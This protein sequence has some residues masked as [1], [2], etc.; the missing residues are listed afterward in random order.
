MICPRW[1]VAM[2]I[3]VVMAA[4]VGAGVWGAILLEGHL[5]A[6]VRPATPRP[7]HRGHP[8]PCQRRRPPGPGRTPQLPNARCRFG[9]HPAPPAARAP[10]GRAGRLWAS[11]PMAARRGPVAGLPPDRGCAAGLHAGRDAA[12][13]AV[14]GTPEGAGRRGAVRGRQHRAVP[15]GYRH[16]AVAR[17][18]SGA[19]AGLVTGTATAGGL[20]SSPRRR[21]PPCDSWCSPELPVNTSARS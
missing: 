21:G 17:V 20:S 6:P 16:L 19:A 13:P 12:R 14:G 7:Q 15:R 3:V 4:L 8:V 18:L 10:A 2:A 9:H 11:R 5:A 1:R